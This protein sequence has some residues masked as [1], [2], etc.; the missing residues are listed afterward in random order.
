M[1]HTGVCGGKFTVASQSHVPLLQSLLQLLLQLHPLLLQSTRLRV[2]ALCTTVLPRRHT[3]VGGGG[4]A[5]AAVALLAIARGHAACALPAGDNILPLP[6]LF[7]ATLP[8][9]QVATHLLLIRA[10]EGSV[11]SDIVAQPLQRGAVGRLQSVGDDSG[12]PLQQH[13]TSHVTRH[14]SHVTRHTHA[15]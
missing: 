12:Q 10:H 7:R 14:T 8:P 4:A 5:A 3:R 6:S 9:L 2:P 15:T 1:T 11:G 13:V